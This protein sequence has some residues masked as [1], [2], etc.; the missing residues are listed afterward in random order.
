MSGDTSIFFDKHRQPDAAA[1]R[2]AY[3]KKSAHFGQIDALFGD[4]KRE[5]KYYGKKYGWNYKFVRERGLLYLSFNESH[6]LAGMAVSA[7]ERKTLL[8]SR[9]AREVKA[10]LAGAKKVMEGYPIRIR[11]RNERDVSRLKNVLAKIGRIP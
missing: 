8:A 10:E 1:L 5:W 3:G 11:V 9:I 2:K 6:M 7:A 4:V